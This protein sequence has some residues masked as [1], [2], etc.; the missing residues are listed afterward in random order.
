MQ[1]GL[2]SVM[3][4]LDQILHNQ[5]VLRYVVYVKFICL[6]PRSVSVNGLEFWAVILLLNVQFHEAVGS[7]KERRTLMFR[8][9]PNAFSLL[10]PSGNFTYHQ[11]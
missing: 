4:V 7:G 6:G 5:S 10:K 3:C 1:W 2:Q 11:V 9:K 8:I